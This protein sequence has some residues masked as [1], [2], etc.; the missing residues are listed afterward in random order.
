M[1]FRRRQFLVIQAR[2]KAQRLAEI[3]KAAEEAA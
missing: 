1:L 2:L 3:K